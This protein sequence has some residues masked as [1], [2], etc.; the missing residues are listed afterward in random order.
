MYKYYYFYS[1]YKHYK[2]L[3]KPTKRNL[4]VGFDDLSQKETYYYWILHCEKGF[5]ISFQKTMI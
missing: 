1:V 2:G 4:C 5:N 3:S